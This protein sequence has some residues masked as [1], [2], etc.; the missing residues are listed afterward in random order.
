MANRQNL[1]ICFYLA[2]LWL[3]LGRAA[4]VEQSNP[5]FLYRYDIRSPDEIKQAGGFLPRGLSKI[6]ELT[7]DSDLSIFN[8]AKALGK[9]SENTDHDAAGGAVPA[10]AGFPANSEAWDR[11][12]WAHY[13]P[14]KDTEKMDDKD[15]SANDFADNGEDMDETND[16]GK[17]AGKDEKDDDDFSN[18]FADNKK[19]TGKKDGKD[20]KDD[21]DF[22]NPFADETNDNRKKGGKDDTEDYN[23]A[24]MN[25]KK[26]AFD[27]AKNYV[28]KQLLKKVH[29]GK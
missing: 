6:G 4:P 23:I 25:P 28:T 8:H 29:P 7:P 13:K 27:Y 5:E 1:L 18:P 10:L 12:P 9:D 3:L 17:K 15:E 26:A 16:N 11:E 21:D 19:D 14:C 2:S 22:Y 20:N 24:C